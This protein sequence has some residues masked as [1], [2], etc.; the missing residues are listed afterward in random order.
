MLVNRLQE[1]DDITFFRS[2][3]PEQLETILKDSPAHIT[4]IIAELLAFLLR[5]RI[6]VNEAEEI[7]GKVR[8]KKM[9]ELFA[10]MTPID[11]PA[12]QAKIRLQKQEIAVQQQ[13]IN[14][15]KQELEKMKQEI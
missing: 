6:P 4:G 7:A 15:Q 9:G 12:E 3:P 2:L 8:E 13:K 1:L 11:I 10:D 5:S 14:A